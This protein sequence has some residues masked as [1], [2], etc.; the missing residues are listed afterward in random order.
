[1]IKIKPQ[2]KGKFTDWA[3]SHN[4]GVQ[5]AASKIMANT[6][7]YSPTLVKRANFAK[8]AA[9]WKHAMGGTL[10]QYQKAGEYNKPYKPL[11]TA[12]LEALAHLM[13]GMGEGNS[14]GIPANTYPNNIGYLTPREHEQLQQYM[15]SNSA[16]QKA[17]QM[18]PN[19]LGEYGA[20]NIPQ[21]S[22]LYD[23]IE[24]SRFMKDYAEQN[25]YQQ[26]GTKYEE[27][28][29]LPTYSQL[30][31]QYSPQMQPQPIYDLYPEDAMKLLMQ[32]IKRIA[33]KKKK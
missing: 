32:D 25:G 14:Y 5:E 9:G 11:S 17:W 22:R 15:N 13:R 12:E 7:E 20:S 18:M 2:N 27:M 21:G 29:Y 26:G 6:E 3:N 16:L 4:M 33:K 23:A 1:M 31:E 30:L 8:N 10:K 24:R 19:L 28:I